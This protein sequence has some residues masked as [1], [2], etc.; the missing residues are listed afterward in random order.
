MSSGTGYHRATRLVT[1]QQSV[2]GT[3][4]NFW[5]A[6]YWSA[7]AVAESSCDILSL[8]PVQVLSIG[9][10]P[11][12]SS[13]WTAGLSPSSP[14]PTQINLSLRG[15]WWTIFYSTPERPLCIELYFWMR[16]GWASCGKLASGWRGFVYILCF[17][18]FKS[19]KL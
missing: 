16:M 11:L 15:M 8:R 6:T 5:A 10:T 18:G 7:V 17:L 19:Y 14:H 12:S 9:Y 2:L 3:V 1:D 13:G 4:G